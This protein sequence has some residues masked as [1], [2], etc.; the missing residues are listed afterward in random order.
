MSGGIG[1]SRVALVMGNSAYRLGARLH[2]PGRDADVIA[3]SLKR[4][5]FEPVHL[6]KDLELSRMA[7]AL[8]D[9]GVEADAAEMAVVYFAGHGLELDG[10]TYLIP[11]DADLGH[12]RQVRFESVG[13]N[14]VLAAVDGAKTLRLV[15]L[16]ACRENPYRERMRG[17]EVSRSLGRGL[18]NIEPAGNTL[19]AY[20]AKHGT[21]ARDGAEAE[22]SPYA[23]ALLDHLETPNLEIRLLFGRVRDTVLE[24]TDGQQEPHLYGSLGGREIYLRRLA[25]RALRG[26]AFISYAREDRAIAKPLAE[27]L[28]A[29]GLDVFWDNEIAPGERWSARIEEELKGADL[30]V[31]L[32]SRHALES[33]WVKDEAQSGLEREILMP[34]L[35]EDVAPPLGFR[36]VQ[37]ADLVGW[38]GRF[39]DPRLGSI[40]SGVSQLLD[41]ATSRRRAREEAA[42]RRKQEAD[43]AEADARWQEF[44]LDETEDLSTIEA[45]LAQFG[46]RA[47]LLA[48]KARQRIEAVAES[49]RRQAQADWEHAASANA[50]GSYEAYLGAWPAGEHSGEAKRRLDDLRAAAAFERAMQ[51]GTA[52]ALDEFLADYPEGERAER[53]VEARDALRV[54]AEARDW[55]SAS[56]DNTAAS[57]QRYLQTWP[58]SARAGEAKE[59]LAGLDEEVAWLAAKEANTSDAF[60]AYIGRFPVGREVA[61]ARAGIER[62]KDDAAWD[63]ACVAGTASAL[64]QYLKERPGGAH[65]DE[66]A[67]QLEKL[68]EE[69]A[70]AWAVRSGSSRR[71]LKWFLRKYPGGMRTD[72]AKRLLADLVVARSSRGTIGGVLGAIVFS[73]IAGFVSLGD[74]RCNSANTRTVAWNDA[75]RRYRGCGRYCAGAERNEAGRGVRNLLVWIRVVR[76]HPSLCSHAPGDGRM[77]SGAVAS[78]GRGRLLRGRISL[79]CVPAW[80]AICV[81]RSQQGLSAACTGWAERGYARS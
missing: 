35:V 41:A 60:A 2:N 9:F 48:V 36:Q 81:H 6:L 27:F 39:G 53:A 49:R 42:S 40:E 21:A 63:A 18:A 59:R 75:R 51:E 80:L 73:L 70:F 32:W 62:L 34:V 15:I 12:A 64:H 74:G 72:D 78:G 26:R 52:S 44:R 33:A 43:L 5:G 19:V 20:A 55:A 7:R 3:A 25:S 56:A 23:S 37:A 16:D 22:N 8:G 13:L 61:S 11:V 57:Y 38:R 58:A 28:G 68:K 50:I 65:A 1:R 46:E 47:P 45:W 76:E 10:Q 77:V 79:P 17:V 69:Q 14:D 66:V 31:V 24:A 54:E 29:L 71:K 4:L 30:V 67:S